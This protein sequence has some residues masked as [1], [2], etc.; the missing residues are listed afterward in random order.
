MKQSPTR[1]DSRGHVRELELNRLKIPNRRVELAP[2]SRVRRR[3]VE[4]RSRDSYRLGSD[5]KPSCVE[6]FHRVHEAEMR[7]AENVRGGN[8]H[9]V[10]IKLDCGRRE[11]AKL[12][13]FFTDDNTRR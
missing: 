4:R 9:P 5:A 13:L 7:I 8:A 6:R 12:V 10:E 1:A 11:Q 2:L 3:C